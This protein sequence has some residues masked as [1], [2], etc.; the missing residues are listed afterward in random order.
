MLTLPAICWKY[1]DGSFINK[2]QNHVILSIFKIRKI[3]HIRF[4]GNLIGNMY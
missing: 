2:S 4:V 3:Q 1:Y